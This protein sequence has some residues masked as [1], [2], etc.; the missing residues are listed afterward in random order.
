MSLPDPSQHMDERNWIETVLRYI[1]GFRGY[2]EKEFRRESD[3]LARDWMVGRLRQGKTGLDEVMRAQVDA[4]Q[5]DALPQ[6]ERVRSR[7][8]HFISSLIA[9]AGG[10]SGFFDY[11]RVDEE[12][13]DDVYQLD[14]KLM[15]EV[16]RFATQLQQLAVKTDTSS[17]PA[18][19]LLS[20][21]DQLQQK[22]ARREEMLRG[23][24]REEG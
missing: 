12:M 6:W 4:G 16:D 15:E 24:Q 2:L 17:N 10:Y 7:L 9:A 14:A 22:L 23:L 5:I 21:I 1:P 11:V 3:R 18:S 8:D 20:H 19:E 13:L